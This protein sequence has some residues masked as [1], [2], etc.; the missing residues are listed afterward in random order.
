MAQGSISMQIPVKSN[1][2]HVVALALRQ[3]YTLIVEMLNV[4]KNA[5]FSW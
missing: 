3:Q 5:R 2:A 1:I 4:R